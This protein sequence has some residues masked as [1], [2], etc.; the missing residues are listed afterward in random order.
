MSLTK[1]EKAVR[2]KL[3]DSVAQ[4]RNSASGLQREVDRGEAIRQS[5]ESKES[6]IQV[7]TCCA[8]DIERIV[9]AHFSKVSR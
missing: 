2:D 3:L 8:D 7:L 1:R 9:G 6:R 5:I 4:M